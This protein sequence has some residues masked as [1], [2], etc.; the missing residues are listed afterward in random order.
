MI[1]LMN[2]KCLRRERG[3]QGLVRAGELA[4]TDNAA[5][6]QVLSTK[7]MGKEGVGDAKAEGRWG[8]ARNRESRDSKYK[9]QRNRSN[10]FP[11]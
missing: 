3:K 2:G 4:I 11:H 5:H 6:G 1:W 8:E 7:A 9:C 10:P